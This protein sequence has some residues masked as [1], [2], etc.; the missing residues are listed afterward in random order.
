MHMCHNAIVQR[1]DY[2]ILSYI[3]I[4]YLLLYH[5]MYVVIPE[6]E[7]MAKMLYTHLHRK[8]WY[9]EVMY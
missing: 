7:K 8:K 2:I 9:S 1:A 3:I 4:I 5:N 6:F